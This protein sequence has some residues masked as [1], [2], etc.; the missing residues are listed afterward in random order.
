M[1]LGLDLD[2][3][4]SF[5]PSSRRSSLGEISRYGGTLTQL[6]LAY[7]FL[8]L[9][10]SIL[11]PLALRILPMTGDSKCLRSKRLSSI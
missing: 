6:R 7:T 11:L 5:I 3:L 8:T 10:D 1:K 9:Q 2:L 4:L